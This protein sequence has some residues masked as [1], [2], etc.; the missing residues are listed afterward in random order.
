MLSLQPTI[1]EL[2]CVNLRVSFAVGFAKANRGGVQ[3]GGSELARGRRTESRPKARAS[4][5]RS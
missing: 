2:I 1:S 5:P 4:G 3:A